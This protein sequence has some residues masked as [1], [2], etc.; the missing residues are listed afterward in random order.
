VTWNYCK[1]PRPTAD[2]DRLRTLAVSQ[3]EQM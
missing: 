1:A 2:S 3:T